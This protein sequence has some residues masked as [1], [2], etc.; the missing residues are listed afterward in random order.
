[1]PVADVPE[2]T[3]IPSDALPN[4]LAEKQAALREQA[5]QDV[6]AGNATVQ[7]IN[8][9]RVVEFT[10]AQE[11]GKGKDNN[12]KGNGKDNGKGKGKDNGKG[13]GNGKGHGKGGND[14]GKG[15]GGK[16]SYQS[17]YVELAR[18]GTDRIFVVLVEFGDQQPDFAL[19]PDAQRHE[20]PLHNEIPEPDRRT[21]N[22]TVWTA[23]Y[24]Q[25]YFQNLYFGKG[26]S[27]KN[28][29]ETQSSG[30][31]S[32]DGVVTDWVKVDYTQGRYG[33][34]R[35]D[36]N[37][38]ADVKL[39]IRDA[40]KA[41][42]NAQLAAGQTMDEIKAELATFDVQDRYDLDGDGDFNEPDGWIDHFQIVHAGGDEADGDPIYA[43]DA[44]WSHRWYA[45]LAYGPSC[46][47]GRACN[48]GTPIGGTIN[49]DGTVNETDD[50]TGF[51]VGDYTMQPENGGR[52]VFYHEYVHDLGLP[53]DYNSIMGG[54]NN[55]EHWTLMA[56]SRLGSK[57]DKGIG[58]RG[59]DLG[60]WNKLQLGWLDYEYVE[61]G[62]KKTVKLGASEYN[63][64]RPQAVVVGLPD[65][66]VTHEFDPPF[67][68]EG[69]YYSGHVDN[70]ILNLARTVTVPADDPVLAFQTR[71]DIEAGYDYVQVLADG[72]QVDVWDG[73]QAEWA[74]RT[75][76]LSAYAGQT[77]EL[78][79]AYVTDPAVSGDDPD[80]PDGILLDQITLGGVVIGDAEGGL[81]EWTTNGWIVAGVSYVT[82]HPGYY[83]AASRTY[84]SYDQYL[85]TGPYF[86]GY[87]TALPDKVDHY[88]YQQ[89][90]LISYW[91]TS[92]TNNDTMLHPGEGRNLYIDAHPK[93]FA[94]TSTG[95]LWRSR[96][97]VYDA[98]FGLT[99][100]DKVT[101][102]VD[103]VPNTFGGLKGVPTFRDTDKYFY[104]ELPNHGVKLPGHGVS[105]SVQNQNGTDMTVKVS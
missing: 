71:Y 8:G 37:V 16:D 51:Y 65:K 73:T 80:V 95:A 81:G 35:C 33:T 25:Q 22:S 9:S 4:P 2:S 39:L 56:Q 84:V 5:I 30:R 91:D 87:G 43:T 100:T 52:S 61:A 18:E 17:R 70:S 27:L 15:K 97:Q 3:V 20:G 69:Q 79:F 19:D 50:F 82:S 26:E 64:K 32:V 62:K 85:K 1:M 74:E 59:G 103:G 49:A 23:D 28:Y 44:I 77:I 45:N 83:I 40:A 21:D 75:V 94:Q 63:N 86:F 98:P 24:S 53:D 12:G 67:E 6:L 38:C 11:H 31:Y 14:R 88:A 47:D 68:G 41:W 10:D 48:T 54:D 66:E 96:V 13:G 34:A 60:A 93:P 42:V 105:I 90:L 89:G 104:E 36:S 58:E 101:L 78:T 92:H 76:D 7:T 46:F 57:T 55:N 99:K 102:H 29:M 72:A